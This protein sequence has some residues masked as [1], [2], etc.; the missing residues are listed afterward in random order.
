MRSSAFSRGFGRSLRFIR[1]RKRAIAGWSAL[2]VACVVAGAVLVGYLQVHKV[3]S[4]IHRV[5]VNVHDLGKRPPVYSTTSMNI[6]VFGNDSRAGLD[7]HQQVLLHTG[8]ASQ[9]GN[10][11][12]TIMVLHISP[13]RHLVTAMSIPRDTM[14]PRYQCDAGGGHPG[15]AAD[16]YARERINAMLSI[17]GPQCLWKTVEQVTGIHLDHFIEIGLGGFVNVINDLGGVNVCAPFNVD[18]PV[19]G[20][21]LPAGQH[22]IDGVTALAFWRTRENIGEGS[23]LQRIQRDQFMSAQV[24]KGVL[25]SGLLS[26]PVRLFRVLGDLAP[27]LTIDSGMSLTDLLHVG[28]SLHALSSKDVQFVTTPAAPWPYDPNAVEFAQPGAQ[29][30]FA[31]IAHDVTI[32]KGPAGVPGAP[33]ATGT[34]AAPAVV[35]PS[36]SPGTGALSAR[37]RG[38]SGQPAPPVTA[39]AGATP[40]PG[41][42]G[43]VPPSP[44]GSA[45]AIKSLAASNGGISAAAACAADAQAFAGPNSPSIPLPGRLG[46]GVGDGLREAAHRGDP[47]LGELGRVPGQVAVHPDRAQPHPRGGQDVEHP[48]VG[49]VDPGRRRRPG[50]VGEPPE[51]PQVWLVPADLLGGHRQVNGH[52]QPGRGRGEQV[53]V[54]V[55]EDRQLPAGLCQRAQRGSHVGEHWRARPCLHQGVVRAAQ[56]DARALARHPQPAGEDLPVGQPIRTG[57]QHEL[58]LMIGGE[59]RPAVHA[60]DCFECGLHAGIP[61]CER[62]VAVE[63]DP[64]VTGHPLPPGRVRPEQISQNR[65]SKVTAVNSNGPAEQDNARLPK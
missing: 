56:P 44:S 1:R 7:R 55:G 54:A 26:D 63:G 5:P 8:D 60:G 11:S 25:H 38:A 13:G 24:V 42:S 62:S 12:D 46:V 45:G 29:A 47:P 15:Q 48:A 37:S 14:V 57:L 30:M 23:D 41:V 18:N 64:S 61:V 27:N 35:T 22:H 65:V 59:Q 33:S 10:L 50:A 19:S 2:A 52:R 21:V 20:L 9:G 49:D 39:G 43:T 3:V 58:R 4:E 17:G 28:E 40:S 32:P 34:A 36:S 31:A 53:I 51:M 16:P 6:L